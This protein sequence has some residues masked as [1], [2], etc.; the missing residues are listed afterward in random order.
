[1][2]RNILKKYN[3]LIAF[4]ISV[5]GVGGVC[6]LGGCEYGTPGE[7]Y[8]TPSARFKVTGTVTNETNAKISNIRVVM[9]SGESLGEQTDTSFT[10][11]NGAY[12]VQTLTYPSEQ[13]FSI[14][15]DDIDGTLNGIYQSKDSIVS[16]KNPVFENGND[17]WYQGETSKELN[18]KLKAGS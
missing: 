4:L 14:K 11:I 1:M 9:H 7:E 3:F 18:I 12:I 17:P 13:D 8:G 5:L 2:K 15:F 6:G 16:F 10:D